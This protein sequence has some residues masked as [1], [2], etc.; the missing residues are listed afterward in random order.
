MTA[1]DHIPTRMCPHPWCR[2]V[3]GVTIAVV[4]LALIPSLGDVWLWIAL[5]ALGVLVYALTRLLVDRNADR[6]EEHR[7]EIA[8]EDGIRLVRRVVRPAW[9][10]AAIT[11]DILL[12]LGSAVVLAVT[13]SG[14]PALP[15]DGL[16]A[17]LSNLPS[18]ILPL[19]VVLAMEYCH[20]KA[21]AVEQPAVGKA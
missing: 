3:H 5:P 10:R 6:D 1:K 21:T 2:P 4:V 17:N 15:A 13:L 9:A 20:K 7:E 12:L 14:D 18:L 19:T 16:R 11:L 8:A